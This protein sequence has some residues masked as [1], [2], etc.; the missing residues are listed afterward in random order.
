MIRKYFILTLLFTGIQHLSAF[1]QDDDIFGISKKAKNPKSE[2]GMGNTIRNGLEFFALELSTGGGYHQMSTSFFSESPSLYPLTQYKNFDNSSFSVND[3]LNLMGSEWVMPLMNGGIRVNLFNLLTIGGGYGRE[4]GNLAPMRG[5]NHEFKFE[6]T[7]YQI[8]KVYGTLGLVLF[9][10]NRRQQI[11]KWQYKKYSSSNL[12]MQSELRQRARLNY[13]WRFIL[14][15]EYG[16]LKVIKYSDPF[17]DKL[18]EPSRPRLA[19]SPDPYFGAFL[20]MEYDFSEYAKMF[21]K[22]GGEMRKFTFQASDFS[23]FQN[24]NQRVYSFQAGV[25][26]KIPGTKRCKIKGCGVVMKHLHNGI[27]Y[28]GSS[29]FRFQNR[30]IGQW[31]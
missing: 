10:A 18:T 25:S 11:L 27:E 6:G 15:G 29:I 31:Y 1:C 13:P 16:N 14:E 2:S 4:W 3:T 30:K 20:R 28:R 24:I 23:E 8:S 7:T 19:A 5:N 26:M 22:A 21:L 12:Y 17:F 9:D